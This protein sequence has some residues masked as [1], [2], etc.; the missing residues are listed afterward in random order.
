M[1]HDSMSRQEVNLYLPHMRGADDL[2]S[3]KYSAFYIGT[4]LVLLLLMVVVKS[5]QGS[6]LQQELQQSETE[7]AQLTTQVTE[8][9]ERLPK[10]QGAQLD[11]DIAELRREVARR[12][13]IKRLISGQDL[14]NASGFSSYMQGLA[15]HANEQMALQGF[16]L[17]TGGITI[18]LQG[19]VQKAQVLPAYLAALQGDDDFSGSRFGAMQI[20]RDEGRLQFSTNQPLGERSLGEQP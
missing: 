9:K 8:L 3:F 18:G 17:S 4:W 1:G 19:E 14:G 15:R 2:L 16:Q 6:S 20:V 7:L 5:W 12:N 11:Q 10:S 13:A